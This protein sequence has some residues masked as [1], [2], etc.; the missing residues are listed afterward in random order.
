[1]DTSQLI[2]DDKEKGRFRYHRSALVSAEVLELERDKV[3][4][5]CW[6]YLGHH[7]ELAKP[8]DYLR[9]MVAERPLF[10]VRG[11]DG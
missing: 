11:A 9:R 3:F 6:L 10:F 5:K 2:I 8:G 1:M 7:S 4:G